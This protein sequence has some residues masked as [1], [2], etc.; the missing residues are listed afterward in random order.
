MLVLARKLGEELTIGESVLISILEISN[1][2]VKV[3]I[4]T[5]T[6]KLVIS[7]K[8]GDEFILDD[9]IR[10]VITG[11]STSN[12]HIGIDAPRSVKVLRK[13]LHER[14]TKRD[15]SVRSC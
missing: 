2:K 4:T 8:N 7:L 3:L 14:P 6:N 13:E 9:S 5:K 12:T 1:N 10:V 15:D 11:V